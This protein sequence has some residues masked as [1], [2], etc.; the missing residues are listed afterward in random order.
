MSA[1]VAIQALHFKVT[2]DEALVITQCFT[3]KR[4][5]QLFAHDSYPR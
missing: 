2:D 1:H 4:Q 5:S 3:Q